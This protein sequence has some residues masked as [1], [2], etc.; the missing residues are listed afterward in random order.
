MEML[1]LLLC[2][3]LVYSFFV[4]SPTIATNASGDTGVAWYHA[5]DNTKLQ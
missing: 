4:V 3:L 5:G 1:Q 2:P